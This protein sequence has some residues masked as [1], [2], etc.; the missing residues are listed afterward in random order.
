MYEILTRE[1]YF[2]EFSFSSDISEAVT[3]GKRPVIPA[4]C[5]PKYKELI[6]SCWQQSAN[7]RPK[8]GVLLE[9]FEALSQEVDIYKVIAKLCLYL[10][11]LMKTSS[12]N[13]LSKPLVRD[14]QKKYEEFENEVS[15]SASDF[16]SP[17]E[18]E[19][20]PPVESLY[21]NSDLNHQ[22]NLDPSFIKSLSPRNSAYL[23]AILTGIKEL[24]VQYTTAIEGTSLRPPTTSISQLFNDKPRPPP[25][26]LSEFRKENV[27]KAA[28]KAGFDGQSRAYRNSQ[29]PAA[30]TIEEVQYDPVRDT[31]G[32]ASVSV[33]TPEAT[34]SPPE[35]PVDRA[36][37]RVSAGV[38][39]SYDSETRPLPP[40][41]GTVKFTRTT[42]SSAFKTSIRPSPGSP[43]R[44]SG[45]SPHARTMP[46]I[47][48]VPITI[49]A[50][51]ESR[52]RTPA[53]VEPR[54]SGSKNKTPDAVDSSPESK[55]ITPDPVEPR[56]SRPPNRPLPARPSNLAA[57]QPA[58]PKLPKEDAITDEEIFIRN[59]TK[60]KFFTKVDCISLMDNIKS[61]L[62]QFITK[63]SNINSAPKNI[64]SVVSTS[65]VLTMAGNCL[66]SI[67]YPEGC[68][69]ES[70]LLSISK[71]LLDIQQKVDLYVGNPNDVEANSSLSKFSNSLLSQI[72][73]LDWTTFPHGTFKRQ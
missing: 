28:S 2:K 8:F 54:P 42:T 44:P 71:D 3:K 32:E 31:Q 39:A 4:K 27:R 46:S 45:K 63:L 53:A 66:S 14:A 50:S 56:A 11:G 12:T 65:R 52:N 33:P 62:K 55:N 23:D 49:S 64:N 58:I 69:M 1:F 37:K 22:L 16:Y 9:Q 41:L 48:Q 35:T 73:S 57:S 68:K 26:N 20:F 70:T 30:Y 59:S 72:S 40:L 18:I 17:A 5:I 24:T 7:K 38:L 51:R 43:Q 67:K 36:S 21:R 6:E 25:R 10:A 47:E 15:L 13:A 60:L 19:Q 34:P 29:H 61:L